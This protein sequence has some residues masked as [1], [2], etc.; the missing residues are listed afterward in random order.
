MRLH[1]VAVNC[2]D[3]ERS[4][5]FYTEGLGLEAAHRWDAP[6]MVSAAAFLPVGDGSWIELFAGGEAGGLRGQQAAGLTHLAIAVDDVRA[7][8]DA[9]VA[10][11]GVPADPPAT[12]TLHGEPEMQATMAFV[13][14]P[15][16]EVVELY[17]NDDLAV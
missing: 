5:G 14:G 17:R 1:H 13:V 7:A 12:R 15:D 9:L 2:T 16:G 3:L 10:A 4:V 8:F 11:G 6:P